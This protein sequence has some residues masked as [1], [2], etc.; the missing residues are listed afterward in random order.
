VFYVEEA[1]ATGG[2]LLELGC[3]TGRLAVPL[4]ETGFDVHG[5]DASPGMLERVKE[6]QKQ[7]PPEI[8]R[9]LHL[10]EGDMAS[11]ELGQQFALVIVAFRSFQHLLNPAAQRNCLLCIRKH[12]AP[13]GTAILNLFDPRYDLIVPGRTEST[14]SDIIHPESGNR[15]LVEVLER[16]ND[17]VVQILEERWRFTETDSNGIVVRSEEEY[18][19]LRWSFRSEMRHLFELCGFLVENEYLDFRRSPPAY[20][21]EQIWVLRHS[22]ATPA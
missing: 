21:K 22:P 14:R 2:P 6:K 16:F 11:F 1:R 19:T 15:V 20:G 5:L 7:L 18:L 10:H 3:G 8:A 17:P 4:L 12:L 13:N 9:R